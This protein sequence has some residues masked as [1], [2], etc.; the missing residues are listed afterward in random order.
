MVDTT[1]VDTTIQTRDGRLLTFRDGGD[2]SGR[3]VFHLHGAPG[4]RL[5]RG[6]DL[7]HTG[8]GIRLMLYDRPGYGRSQRQPGRTVVDAVPD[9]LDIANQ[10][11]LESF[12]VVGALAVAA[13]L[14]PD[15][16][17]RCSTVCGIGPADAEDLDFFAGMDPTE[18]TEW[19][20][21]T[22]L[23]VDRDRVLADVRE[24]IE[25]IQQ[26]SELPEE[27][28]APRGSGPVPTGSLTTT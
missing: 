9:I 18:V 17:T 14:A 16:V 28:K 15:R 4:K 5:L 6:P 24:W 11:K 7:D 13:A 21:F 25:E 1:M 10:L 23:D 8:L 27:V 3:P 19:Q 22:G 26:S 2:R 12:G 20:V